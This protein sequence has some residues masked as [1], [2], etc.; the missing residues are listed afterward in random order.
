MPLKIVTIISYLYLV[1]DRC[2]RRMPSEMSMV[3]N[4]NLK[5]LTQVLPENQPNSLICTNYLKQH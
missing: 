2:I 5:D 1:S 3:K 4:V